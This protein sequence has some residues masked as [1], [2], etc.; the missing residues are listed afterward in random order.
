MQNQVES[1]LRQLRSSPKPRG[2]HPPMVQRYMPLLTRT[3]SLRIKKRGKNLKISEKTQDQRPWRILG[4][5]GDVKIS[6]APPSRVKIECGG[7]S[8]I[9]PV[10]LVV[11]LQTPQ[12]ID[13]ISNPSVSAFLFAHSDRESRIRAARS[14]ASL[15]I[16]RKRR[17]FVDHLIKDHALSEREA[18]TLA[19]A[20]FPTHL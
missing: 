4:E 1:S 20:K 10:Q 17:D 5:H 7:L 3:D 11:A 13:F 9:L 2:G 16:G 8:A 18:W 6:I 14:I 19:M 15:G 12:A